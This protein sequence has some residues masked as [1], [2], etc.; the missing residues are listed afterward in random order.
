MPVTKLTISLPED[1]A[2]TI[3]AEAEAEGTTVSAWL[4]ERARRALLFAESRA[5]LADYEAEHG[6]ITDE[7]RERARQ[8]A[9]RSTPAH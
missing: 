3:R 9:G 7:E 8:W 4:G 1:L 6:K 2:E 5:A